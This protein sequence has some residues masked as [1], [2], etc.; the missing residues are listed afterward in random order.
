MIR[1]GGTILVIGLALGASA[2]LAQDASQVFRATVEGVRVDVAVTQSGRPAAGL[3]LADFEILDNGVPQRPASLSFDTIPIDVTIALDVS[4]SVQGPLLRALK[5]GV[6]QVRARLRPGDRLRLLTFNSRIQ[7]L[8]DFT[9]RRIDVN[10][11]FGQ[12]AASGST[13]IFDTLAV[14]L[15]SEAPLDRRQLVIL[16]S[17]GVDTVSVTEQETLIA[18]A[19]RSPA[20]LAFVLPIPLSGG[21]GRPV[22]AERLLRVTAAGTPERLFAVLAHETGGIVVSAMAATDV[23]TTFTEIFD[24]FRSVYVLHYTPSGVPGAGFHPLTVR[25][26]RNGR[27]EVRARRGYVGD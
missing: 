8:I 4:G 9:D 7:R 27:Y 18:I 24:A 22:P 5:F 15:S 21:G 26:T 20:M 10:E 16:F 11:A 19:Q 12:I 25:V 17:D 1:A 2:L 14:A 23:P 13:A 6:D 3:E